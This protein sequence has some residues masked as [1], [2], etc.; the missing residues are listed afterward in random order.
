MLSLQGQ[1]PSGWGL[2]FHETCFP[3]YC[4]PVTGLVVKGQPLETI[5]AHHGLDDTHKSRT[6]A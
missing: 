4:G 5:G 1:H 3:P 6:D 2:R